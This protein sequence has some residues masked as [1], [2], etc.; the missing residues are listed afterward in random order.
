MRHQ[1]LL[2]AAIQ[3][4]LLEILKRLRVVDLK[5]FRAPAHLAP[6]LLRDHLLHQRQEEVPNTLIRS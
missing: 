2:G 1:D 3:L 5:R 6:V 4:L